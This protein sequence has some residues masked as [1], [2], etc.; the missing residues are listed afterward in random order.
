MLVVFLGVWRKGY[1]VRCVVYD[2]SC[3]LGKFVKCI[4]KTSLKLVIVWPLSYVMWVR[5]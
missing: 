3:N 2:V 5:D 1:L 4:S